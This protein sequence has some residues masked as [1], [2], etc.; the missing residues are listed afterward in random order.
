M[1]KDYLPG[2]IVSLADVVCSSDGD[3]RRMLGDVLRDTDEGRVSLVMVSG[4]QS[5][6]G[7][8]CRRLQRQN[9]HLLTPL[10]WFV[11]NSCMY[12]IIFLYFG[13][14]LTASTP[15]VLKIPHL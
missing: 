2:L 1:D 4:A 14:L 5:S 8:G 3:Y 13:S 12:C 7:P 9:I 10:P 6:S 15:K 11:Q